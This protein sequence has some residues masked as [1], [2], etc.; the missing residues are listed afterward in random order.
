MSDFKKIQDFLICPI[1][2]SKLEFMCKN[3]E[4][5]FTNDL[6]EKFY[7]KDN[8]LDFVNNDDYSES[9]GM[10]WNIFKKT[11]LDSYSGHPITYERFW[12]ATSWNKNELKD[13]WVLDLGCGQGRFAEIALEAGANVICVDYSS[14]VHACRENLSKFDN[15]YVLKADI[16]NLPLI[17]ENFEYVYSLGVIQHTP[18]VNQSFNSVID[19][20]Q[21]GG[22]VCVDV[23]FKRFRTMVHGKYLLRPFT[24]KINRES[25]L[26]FLTKVMPFALKL[27]QILGAIPLLGKILKR[28]VPIADYTGIYPLN[29]KQLLEW[30]ILDTFDMLSPAYDNPQTPKTLKTWFEDRAFKNIEVLHSNHLVGRAQRPI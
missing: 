6:E 23:Y 22:K 18:N 5:F 16:N 2:G 27:S 8:V 13:K 24:K 20:V 11:Q 21:P 10:Q 26:S 1:T 12:N 3:N 29:K 9:F 15:C 14:A 4:F 25:L 7:I 17:K 19:M 28:L 30:A